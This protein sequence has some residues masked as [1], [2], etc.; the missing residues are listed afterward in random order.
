MQDLKVDG[1]RPEVGGEP[2]QVLTDAVATLRGSTFALSA[3]SGDITPDT[4][5]GLFHADTRCLSRFEVTLDGQPLDRLSNGQ[6]DVYDA[7]FFLTNAESASMP[8]ESV[9][10]ERRRRVWDGMREELI[11]RSHRNEAL[12]CTLA[13]DVDADFADLFEVKGRDVHKRGSATTRHDPDERVMRFAYEHGP[14]SASTIIAFSEP[15]TFEGNRAL[16]KVD[17]PPRGIWRVRVD[18]DWP[19]PDPGAVPVRDISDEAI[20]NDWGPE[21]EL[22]SWRERMPTLRTGSD[23]LRRVWDRSLDDLSSLRLEMQLDDET[24]SLPAAGMP[25]FM[26]VFGR[27]TIITSFQT[28]PFIPEL[29]RGALLTLAA[30]QGR[31]DVAFQDEEPGKIM[32]E[33][34]FGEL[35]VIGERPHKPYYGT[36]DATPLW[37]VLLSEYHRFTQDDELVRNLWPNVE[38]ALTWMT[39]NRARNEGFLAY[40]TRSTYG[41]RNQGWKDS[42]RGVLFQDGSLPSTPI[43][44]CEVQ[45]YAFDALSRTAE[46]AQHVVG[47]T[48]LAAQLRR[49]ADELATNF[50]HAFWMPAQEHYALGLDGAGR[51]IDGV[52]SNMGHLLWSG[53]VSPE[54]AASIVDRL[55][56]PDLWCGWGVRTLSTGHGGFSPLGYHTGTVWPHD[57]SLITAGLTRYGFRDRAVEIATAM[58]D[59]AAGHGYRLPEAFAGFDRRDVAYPVRYPTA[60]DPQAWAS[61]APLL[62]LR[63]LLG[64]EPTDGTVEVDPVLPEELC[65]L[66]LRGLSAYGRRWD[67]E[68]TD[69]RTASV[70]PR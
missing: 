14:F 44:L 16:F 26:A 31:E 3:P 12:T 29:A 62:W 46:L 5:S 4:V 70:A 13:I 24:A 60:S 47:N 10:L 34:R 41:L 2:P 8:A 7:S 17:V 67:V 61:A 48:T 64:L 18:V 1:R 9:T 38:R 43:A 15:V 25:W 20:R 23:L 68:V 56:A 66:E 21:E 50:E 19:D 36:I 55:F 57:N 52:T 49:R 33:L 45:G 32:H 22:R 59:A 54:R 53:I 39:D 63:V 37:L 27:D 69:P 65:P 6:G 11:I 42:D 51:Q 35:T 40:E 28:V 58:L 30:L